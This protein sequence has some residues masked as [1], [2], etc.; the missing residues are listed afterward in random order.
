MHHFSDSTAVLVP[1]RNAV[2]SHA[3]QLQRLNASPV[4]EKE[5]EEKRKIK[6]H[7]K[8]KDCRIDHKEKMITITKKASIPGTVAFRELA[9]SHRLYP[10]YK[11]VYRTVRT[12]SR[13]AI[14]SALTVEKMDEYIRVYYPGDTV[15]KN[16]FDTMN[17][18][19]KLYSNP[20]AFMRKWFR[21]DYPEY[22]EKA[23]S[24]KQTENA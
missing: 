24:D 8:T 2:V 1:T 19:S 12:S 14:T 5:R 21:N 15:R 3:Q 17:R 16:T 22:W 18:L 23:E 4:T 13:R 10:D 7:R 6:K 20:L 11:I 9:E